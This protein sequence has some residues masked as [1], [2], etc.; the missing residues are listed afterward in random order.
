MNA[1]EKQ[2][3]AL[4]RLD[5]HGK[6]AKMLQAMREW[7]ETAACRDIDACDLI[8]RAAIQHECYTALAVFIGVMAED[9]DLRII[10]TEMAEALFTTSATAEMRTSEQRTLARLSHYL[11]VPDRRPRTNRRD[12]R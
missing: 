4:V 6:T 1:H 3:D 7:I 9:D 10:G 11:P 8:I 12:D 2:L 5:P